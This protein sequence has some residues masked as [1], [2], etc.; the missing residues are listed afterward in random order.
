MSKPRRPDGA[1]GNLRAIPLLARLTSRPV[2]A[3]SS[4][5]RIRSQHVSRPAAYSPIVLSNDLEAAIRRLP[6]IE[7]VRVVARGTQ[8]TE[9]HV[10]TVPGKPAKQV[11]RDVQS[12]AIATLGTPIDRRII[13]VVQVHGEGLPGE[14]ARVLDVSETVTG[15]RMDV[16]VTL[17]WH[18][19]RLVG[20]ADGPAATST[21]LHLVAVA[22]LAA[23]SEVIDDDTALAVTGTNVTT[24]GS[25]HVALAMIVLVALEGERTLVGA[26]LVDDDDVKAMARATLDAM[27][28]Q[29]AIIT[30]R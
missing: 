2:R 15:T 30:D 5:S 28:R 6:D 4:R 12:I 3:K 22:T 17:T 1:N 23:L 26:A 24:I 11:V 18:N 14:R 10:V 21:R 27:N 13:S 7:A 9:V 25:R 8:P 16:Q 20:S 29:L 19:Q